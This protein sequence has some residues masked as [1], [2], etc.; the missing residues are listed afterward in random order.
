MLEEA[1]FRDISI[2]SGFTGLPATPDDEM[3]AYLAWP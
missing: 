3:V 2:E 1:G